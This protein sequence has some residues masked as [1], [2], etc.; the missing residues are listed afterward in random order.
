MNTEIPKGMKI[1]RLPAGKAYGADDLNNWGGKYGNRH[2]YKDF[3][4]QRK[5]AKKLSKIAGHKVKPF[6]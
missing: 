2:N 5:R 4:K 6:K 3:I 1:K